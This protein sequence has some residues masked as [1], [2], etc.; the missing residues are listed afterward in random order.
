MGTRHLT[1][2]ASGA[3]MLYAKYGQWDGYPTGV[4]Y[5]IVD[6]LWEHFDPVKMA[7]GASK[8]TFI[9]DEKHHLKHGVKQKE[10]GWISGDDEGWDE[11]FKRFPLMTRNT[12][13]GEVFRIIQEGNKDERTASVWNDEFGFDSLFCEW[14]YV[15]DMERKVL[16]VYKG[17][18]RTPP[19][20][21][22]WA[23]REAPRQESDGYYPVELVLELELGDPEA[24][25]KLKA[26]EEAGSEED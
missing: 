6:Y 17:F 2:L 18:Q 1:C 14:A 5:G 7:E 16:E 3:V 8:M 12:S 13:G 21:G 4:G 19:T 26:L 20:K 23:E 25:D 22:R 10:A 24:K 9:D 11:Y 15:F